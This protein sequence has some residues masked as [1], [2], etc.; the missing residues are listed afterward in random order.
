MLLFSLQ[1]IFSQTVTTDSNRVTTRVYNDST[2]IMYFK[3]RLLVRVDTTLR[4]NQSYIDDVYAFIASQ[5]MTVLYVYEDT[6]PLNALQGFYELVINDTAKDAYNCIQT[7][8]D[9]KLFLDVEVSQVGKL[10]NEYLDPYD[11]DF[12]KKWY[13]KQSSNKDIDAEKAWVITK[14][15]ETKV[16]IYVLY[17]RY[18]NTLHS[19]NKRLSHINK[20]IDPDKNVN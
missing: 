14:G 2:R 10:L 1:T 16:R 18:L 17:T 15:D 20:K 9:S 6:P 8:I 13:C 12:K 5:N 19:A 11:T 3:N 7:F 4:D